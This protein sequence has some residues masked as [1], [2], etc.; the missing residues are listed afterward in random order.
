[1]CLVQSHI[2][3]LAQT[4]HGSKSDEHTAVDAL[5]DD[6]ELAP[7]DQNSGVV[8]LPSVCAHACHWNVCGLFIFVLMFSGPRC[9]SI[10]QWITSISL[11]RI[12][13]YGEIFQMNRI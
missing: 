3:S 12:T 6:R 13:W 7:A 11:G 9:Y 5:V 1:M 2:L 4:E 8:A 10:V